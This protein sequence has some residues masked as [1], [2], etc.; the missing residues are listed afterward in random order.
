MNN[1]RLIRKVTEHRCIGNDYES[2]E[3]IHEFTY[4]DKSGGWCLVKHR[5]PI[6]KHAGNWRVFQAEGMRQWDEGHT[7]KLKRQFE[8][9][10]K[11]WFDTNDIEWETVEETY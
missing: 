2:L 8:M 6:G 10:I 9:D 11:N 1:L 4:A 5:K 7:N 3:T